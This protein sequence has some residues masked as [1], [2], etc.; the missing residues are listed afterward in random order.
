MRRARTFRFGLFA[1]ALAALGAV[2][3]VGVVL[4]SG[5]PPVPA[6]PVHDVP[7]ALPHT[8]LGIP[9]IKPQSS[10][11]TSGGARITKADVVQ[12]VS[13]HQTD[14]QVAGTPSAT[15]ISV[16]FLTSKQV[17]TR[18]HGEST[19]VP[20]DIL[21]CYVRVHGT[22]ET[23]P[24]QGVPAVVYHDGYLVFDAQTGNLL[25]GNA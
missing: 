11:A 16:E 13:T 21:L 20:D 2:L 1:V 24:P 3:L 14:N 9:A 19:G 15:V 6:P 23:N 22:F 4:A 17:S 18:L 25:M 7:L 12:W 8:A 5:Q 10:L